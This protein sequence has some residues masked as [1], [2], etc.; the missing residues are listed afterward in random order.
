MS[1]V[2][3]KGSWINPDMVVAVW[4]EHVKYSDSDYWRVTLRCEEGQV[5]QWKHET[6]E[7]AVRDADNIAAQVNAPVLAGPGVL[8][9][10]GGLR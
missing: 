6:E 5:W 1:V 9:L 7:D 3:V 4:H 8:T 2:R 10:P